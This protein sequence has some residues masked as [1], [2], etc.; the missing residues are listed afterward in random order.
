[1]TTSCDVAIIGTGFA[2]SVQIPGFQLHPR[3]NVVAIAA[4]DPNRTRKVAEK[5]GIERWYTDW[6][7]LVAAGDFD[8]LS[9]V[10]PP[11][12]HC[13]M[14]L[15]AFEKGL[16][17]FC[18]KPMALNAEEARQM[19]DRADE[20]GLTAMIDHEFRHTPPRKRFSELIREGHIGQLRRLVI[21]LH[22]G[23]FTDPKREWHWWNDFQKGGGLLGALGSH[24]FD[25]VQHWLGLPKR[26]WGKLS[27]FVSER[28]LP[29]GKGNRTVTADDSFLAVLDMGNGAEVFFDC[30][31]TANPSTGFSVTALGSEGT[32]LI[33]NDQRLLASRGGEDLRPVDLPELPR[34][35]DNH[36][37]SPFLLLLDELAT[38][39]DQGTSPS[40]NFE[41]GLA[42]Q[43]FIDAVKIS[44]ALGTWVD[45][46][47][48]GSAPEGFLPRS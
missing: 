31:S 17:V 20:T 25:A 36:R 2:D 32:L 6:R 42:H 26:V 19:L 4:R 38:G 21:R 8:L 24:Y 39:I 45:F 22:Q 46:P 28:P 18:E 35:A 11:H 15:A 9:I 7:E 43:Q 14:T 40:P 13:E 10:T 33:D 41:D 37:I 16:H 29:D 44:S 27:V 1:M 23:W 34:T 5:F 30:T 3:F 12:L 48:A 47:P